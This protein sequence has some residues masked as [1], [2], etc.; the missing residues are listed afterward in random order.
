MGDL[1]ILPVAPFLER[2]GVIMGK[3]SRYSPEVRERA[4]RM[5][6]ENQREY[7]GKVEESPDRMNG[8]QGTL[9][10]SVRRSIQAA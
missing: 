10:D 6:L 2:M 1:T 7:H 9:R 3:P 4:V 5:V 8:G